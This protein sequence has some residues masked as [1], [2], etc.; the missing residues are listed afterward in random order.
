[1]LNKEA[2]TKQFDGLTEEEALRVLADEYGIAWPPHDTSCKLWF[3]HVFNYCRAS[4]LQEELDD[5]LWFINFIV[6]PFTQSCFNQEDTVFQGCT[7]TCGRKQT[8]LYFTL[9]RS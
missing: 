9:A 2:I 1:M 4:E 3:A 5:F 8:I 7:C 6:V